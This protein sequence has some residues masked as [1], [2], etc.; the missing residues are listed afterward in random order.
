MEVCN[1]GGMNHPTSAS[2][3]PCQGEMSKA[4]SPSIPEKDMELIYHAN[5][6]IHTHYDIIKDVYVLGE[7]R[8]SHMIVNTVPVEQHEDDYN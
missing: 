2:E 8:R 3:D 1:V 6:D 7:F 5:I 4:R